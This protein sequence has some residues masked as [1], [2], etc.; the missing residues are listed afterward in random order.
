MMTI[1]SPPST[2]PTTFPPPPP[3]PPPAGSWLSWTRAARPSK[4]VLWCQRPHHLP[5]RLPLPRQQRRCELLLL[6]CYH[7]LIHQSAACS[8]KPAPAAAPDQR[9]QPQG[10]DNRCPSS[11]TESVS[12]T[13][14]AAQKERHAISLVFI[15][16]PDCCPDP[17]DHHWCPSR[18]LKKLEHAKALKAAQED[19]VAHLSTMPTGRYSL[20]RSICVC[21]HV[22]AGEQRAGAGPPARW[23]GHPRDLKDHR[24]DEK[25]E[26]T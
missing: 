7:S 11:E 1:S 6:L 8:I 4:E 26:G 21:V 24:R 19:E 12:P 20:N 2:Q 13:D 5:P 22:T 16:H 15:L 25:E 23:Q 14:L 10:D 9:F 18:L 3:P 17:L